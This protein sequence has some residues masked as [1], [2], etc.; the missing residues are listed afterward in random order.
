MQKMVVRLV[1]G[2]LVIEAEFGHMGAVEVRRGITGRESLWIVPI[3]EEAE[4][5]RCVERMGPR[6][7]KLIVES[8]PSLLVQGDE[9]SVIVRPADG[10][11]RYGI[12]A[13]ANIGCAEIS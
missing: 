9:Q 4:A 7:G 5:A 10:R 3:V 2:N 13:V 1:S 12:G 8:M 11:P 6:V